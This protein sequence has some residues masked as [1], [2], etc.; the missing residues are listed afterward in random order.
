M[1]KKPA[2][3][4]KATAVTSSPVPPSPPSSPVVGHPRRQV[5]ALPWRIVE[6][7]LEICLVTT[8]ETRRWT[9]PKGWPMKRLTDRA[10]ARAEAEQEAGVTGKIAKTAVG[11]YTYW[12]RLTDRFDFVRVEVYPLRVVGELAEWKE[13]GEREVRWLS[14]D[15]AARLVDEPELASLIAAFRPAEA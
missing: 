13:K 8:R 3:K 10:A 4:A 11:T 6:G 12:K 15:D 5:A 9:V 14:G 1:P 2:K 7:R